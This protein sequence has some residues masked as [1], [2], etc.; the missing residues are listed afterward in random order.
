MFLKPIDTILVILT[1]VVFLGGSFIAWFIFGSIVI[2]PMLAVMLGII[3]AFVIE[4]FRRIEA[5]LAEQAA[6]TTRNYKQTEAM[7]NLHSTLKLRRP[8]PQMRDY[9]IYPD[10]AST[11]VGLILEEKPKVIL[12]LGSGVSTIISG[13]CLEQLGRGKIWSVEHDKKYAGITRKNLR[14]HEVEK[15]AKVIHAPLKEVRFGDRTW[16]WY[17]RP[18]LKDIKSIDMLVVDGPPGPMQ[19]LSR[20]PALPVLHKQLAPGAIVVLEDAKRRDEK[21]IIKMWQHEFS[22]FKY[23]FFYTQKGAAVF[24]KKN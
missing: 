24:R 10:F 19:K 15:Y 14:L 23:E 20:Y 16:H 18:K 3:T 17:D 1:F 6:Q 2:I 12:E 13:Y 5:Q 9:A 22:D 4:A 21:Q 7:L 11:L 8:L